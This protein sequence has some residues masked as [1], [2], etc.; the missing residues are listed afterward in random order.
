MPGVARRLARLGLGRL[1]VVYAYPALGY[2]QARCAIPRTQPGPGRLPRRVDAYTPAAPSA[3]PVLLGRARSLVRKAEGGA[4]LVDHRRNCLGVAAVQYQA[5]GE[6][7]PQAALH[8]CRDVVV[9]N[10]GE[11][12]GVQSFKPLGIVFAH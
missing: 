9:A 4:N 3:V 1:T 2:A 6:V 12:L 8:V 10:G 5:L 7:G 11:S